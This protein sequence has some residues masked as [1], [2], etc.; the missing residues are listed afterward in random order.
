[1]GENGV[2]LTSGVSHIGEKKELTRGTLPGTSATVAATA[3]AIP[4]LPYRENGIFRHPNN[5][6]EEEDETIAAG[7]RGGL[8]LHVIGQKVH[9]ERHTL[10]KHIEETPELRQLRIDCMEARIDN[11]EYQAD[12]L[13][14]AGNPTMIMFTLERQ[15]RKRGWGV[16]EEKEVEKDESRIVMGMI[17]ELEVGAAEDKIEEIKNQTEQLAVSAAGGEN[18][19][20]E[21]DPM[22]AGLE[23][24]AALDSTL[25]ILREQQDGGEPVG[26]RDDEPSETKLNPDRVSPPPYQQ[27]EQQDASRQSMRQQSPWESADEG[28]FSDDPMTAFD[29]GFSDG[30]MGW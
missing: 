2:S 30:S 27:Q 28:G 22:K 24:Q 19:V 23:A 13:V 4:A 29:D 26:R 18:K 15:G 7:L 12:R 1:M 5:W 16:Q 6:T 3:A 17:P 21:S 8:P 14:Q 11:A 25:G 10:A 9:C 20:F